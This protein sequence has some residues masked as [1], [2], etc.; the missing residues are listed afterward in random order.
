M[1]QWIR[2][3]N[4][5]TKINRENCL[6]H[7]SRNLVEV[8]KLLHEQLRVNYSPSFSEVITTPQHWPG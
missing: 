5:K 1:H 2:M 3:Q 7:Q 6:L 8:D 4:F